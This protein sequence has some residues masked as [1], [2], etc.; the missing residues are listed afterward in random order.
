MATLADLIR[1]RDDLRAARYSGARVFQD[2]NG[3]RIE[4]RS[5][6]ELAAAMAA[7]ES[8]IA[9]MAAKPASRILP[10]TS[11]GLDR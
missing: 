2:Q 11:R 10:R 9:A 3:E 7:L 8:E 6:R 4:Y 1:F 5:D